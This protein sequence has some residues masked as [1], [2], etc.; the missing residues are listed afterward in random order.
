[1]TSQT[2]QQLLSDFA[3]HRSEAAFSELVRRH[4]D[5]VYSA[6][7][8]MVQD[9]HLAKD[10]AQGVFVALAQ[11][12]AQLT[13]RPSLSGWLH[14]TAQNLAANI[15]RT[16][17]RR[18]AR[19][20]EAAAMNESLFNQAD[21]DWETIA[22]HLDAALGELS[23]PDR[24]A[25]LLRY[26][27]RQSAREMAQTLGLSDEAAQK[28]VSRAVEK[29]REFF[30]RRGIS[31][32][33]GG[34]A[35]VISANAVQAAPAGLAAA[36]CA[37]SLT[38][39]AVATSAAVT[40]TKTIA[41]TT[42]QK[43]AITAALAALAGAG[44]Y[45]ARQAAQ[46]RGENQSLRQRMD[47]LASENE[48]LAARPA[49]EAQ[50]Q[51]L[52]LASAPAVTN[53]PL[54]TITGPTNFW[55]SLTNREREVKLTHE[56]AESF[57]AANGRSAANLLAAFRTTRDA[58]LLQEAMSK[59]PNDPQVAFEATIS[60]SLH[61]SPAEQRQWLDTF[62]KSAPNNSMANYL[63]AAN[64]FDAGDIEHGLQELTA[65][66]GKKLDDY[67][68]S[69]AQS[70]IEAFQGAGY[71]LVE[72]TQ[73]G[74]SQLVLPQLSQLKKLAM[75]SADLASA[76]RKAGDN[77][78]AQNALQLAD[79][80]GRQYATPS[81]GEPLVSQL[82]GIAI[83]RVALAGMDPNASYG[84]NGQTVQDRLN[85]LVQ[86]RTQIQQMAR[87]TESILPSLSPDDLI[88]YKNRWLMLGE[89]NAEQWLIDKYGHQ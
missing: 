17:V 85:Q 71:S 15:I 53:Q 39:T 50:P 77:D 40:A 58:S 61:L 20:Q 30:A 82:V 73:F 26:F 81:T 57:L 89:Q 62:E 13:D 33:A 78:A 25:V 9:T 47:Q 6:A 48:K 23:E 84:D 4:I 44:I 5:F 35:V 14:R 70:D 51:P 76:Y 87:Q 36:I 79:N 8:R 83:E 31:I 34:L 10:V 43:I 74:T 38:G 16:D 68:T 49:P 52:L 27:A 7:L 19:E 55:A 1:V 45:E 60:S 11:N 3:G 41:M 67:N 63:S 2:D 18:R 46:L 88:T 54:L 12:A 69:R 32:G 28:R 75:Q 56:Q 86:Q 59:F 80:L 37:A 24:E 72:A 42:F 65:A 64:Y 66:A 22:F 29:L 21:A